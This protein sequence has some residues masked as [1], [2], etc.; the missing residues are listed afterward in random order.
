MKDERS[1]V[2]SWRCVTGILRGASSALNTE[3][4]EVRAEFIRDSGAWKAGFKEDIIEGVRRRIEGLRG[5]DVGCG[6]GCVRGRDCR[7]GRKV[8]RVRIGVRR[9]VLRRSEMVLGE[10]AAIGEE[11]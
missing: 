4:R 6:P 10:R 9:R 7:S 5:A 11:G 1:K 8:W 3:E 2:P